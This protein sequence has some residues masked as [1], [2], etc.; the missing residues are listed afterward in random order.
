MLP[1][2]AQAKPGTALEDEYESLLYQLIVAYAGA[3]RF[4]DA[5]AIHARAWPMVQR[6]YQPT[7]YEYP[8]YNTYLY[9]LRLAEGR[10]LDAEKAIESTHAS[11]ATAPAHRARFVNRS[12][13]HLWNIQARLGRPEGTVAAAQ[14]IIADMDAL[15]GPGNSN[16]QRM[17]ADLARHFVERGDYA[18]AARVY[19]ELE[20][21]LPAE[22]ATHPTLRLPR[23]SAALLARTLAYPERG[24]AWL[25]E[26]RRLMAELAHNPD[27]SG[28]PWAEA[29][30]ALARV[31][32]RLNDLDLAER[33]L[34]PLGDLQAQP[35]LAVH[36]QLQSRVGQLAGELARARGQLAASLV[37]LR[38]HVALLDALPAPQGLPHWRAQ[39]DLAA[40]LVN[41]PDAAAALARA[42][43]LRPD[44]LP[45]HPLDALRAELGRG[46]W[47]PQWAGQF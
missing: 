26:A 41:T 25:E 19:D 30:L 45:P 32:L 12:R 23:A 28:P 38:E 17:R 27:I 8:Y 16:S 21:G 42:D 20:A 3:A 13:Q 47:H 15:L 33:A 35:W 39:L 29:G 14:Q 22:A 1:A 36:R 11:W 6:L 4:A 18:Q 24:R 7:D 46:Q 31:G 40:S 10:L 43:T 9:Q 5:E 37:G 34:A 44:W 2:F